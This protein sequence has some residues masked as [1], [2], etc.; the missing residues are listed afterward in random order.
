M[1]PYTVIEMLDETNLFLLDNLV[2]ALFRNGLHNEEADNEVDSFFLEMDCP[3]FHD[4]IRS[5]VQAR[6]EVTVDRW[7]SQIFGP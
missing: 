5:Y 3:M 1:A 2:D 4:E 6:W 7:M